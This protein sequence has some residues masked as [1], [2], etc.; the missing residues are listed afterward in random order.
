[1]T[2]LHLTYESTADAEVA[3]ERLRS[4]GVTGI[5]LIM[6]EPVMDSRDGS[7]GTFAGTTPA[8]DET[9]GSFAN[10]TLSGRA[11]LG[12]YAGDPDK[13]RRGGFGD[14]DRDTVTTYDR[15]VKRT[16]VKSH[17]G[18]ENILVDAGLDRATAAAS[19]AALHAGQVLV[20]V[21]RESPLD[22]VAPALADRGLR[23]AA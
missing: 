3:I 19:V 5:E 15:G 4:A 7:V 11:A 14:T 23:A 10:I 2:P 9:V 13:Q 17:H 8:D 22:D 20:L 12:T 6:G 16:R 21:Q 18:L 1:M